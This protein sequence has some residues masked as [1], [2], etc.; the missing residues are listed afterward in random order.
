MVRY[1]TLFVI[2]LA[3]GYAWGMADAVFVA[4][5]VVRPQ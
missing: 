1:L 5:A 3:A 2:G 4:D